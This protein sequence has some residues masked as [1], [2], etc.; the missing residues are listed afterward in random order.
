[1]SVVS[2]TITVRFD[3]DGYHRWPE[4][5]GNRDYLADRHR[6]RFGFAVTVPVT[7]SNRQ[8]E[9]HDLLDFC[10]TRYPRPTE[11]GGR[12]CEDIAEELAGAVVSAFGVGD[13]VEVTVSEDGQVEATVRMAAS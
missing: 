8:I 5:A 1:M 13:G 9:F 2:R 7:H 11:F 3:I 6:H 10:Q 12:S 4:A